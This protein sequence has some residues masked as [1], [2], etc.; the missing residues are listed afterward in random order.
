MKR[1]IVLI[2][3][4]FLIFGFTGTVNALPINFGFEEGGLSGWQSDIPDGG[5][6]GVVT[7]HDGYIA[8]EGQKFVKLKANY[9]PGEYTQIYQTFD[10][11]AGEK[12][13]GLAAFNW[14]DYPDFWDHAWVRIY[15]GDNLSTSPFI[16]RWEESGSGHK[17]YWDGPWEEWSFTATGT[18]SYTL[19]YGVANTVDG[20]Y[21]SFAYFDAVQTSGSTPGAPVPEPGTMILLSTGLMSVAGLMRR[22]R[23][24]GKNNL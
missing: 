2:G 24:R 10:L 19:A 9:T 13:S 5:H 1:L 6:V 20:C 3:V 4:A 22:S 21:S 17:G 16:V 7:S 12:I 18:G 15:E 11:D 23:K 14:N 8:K